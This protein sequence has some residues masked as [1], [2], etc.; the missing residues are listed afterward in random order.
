MI[1]VSQILPPTKDKQFFH[2]EEYKKKNSNKD[3]EKS[4]DE[5]LNECMEVLGK[6]GI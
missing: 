6:R 2:Y 3:I 1:T 4:F 5:T